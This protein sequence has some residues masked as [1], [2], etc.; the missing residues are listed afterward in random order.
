MQSLVTSP[1]STAARSLVVSNA[2][3]LAQTLNTVSANIQGL[4]SDAESGSADSVT[5]ANDAMQQIADI[6]KQLAGKDLT[7]ASN[8]ALADQRD[9]M[10]ISFRS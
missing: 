3:V 8:A 1:D 2:Q 6:N 4:R 10:S 5:A 9:N 7:N